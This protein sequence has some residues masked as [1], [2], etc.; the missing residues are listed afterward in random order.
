[1]KR[2]ILFMLCF[3]LCFSAFAKEIDS[4]YVFRASQAGDQ[5]VKMNLSLNIPNKPSQLKIG[6]AGTLGYHYFVTDSINIGGDIGFNYLTTIGENVFYF[7]PFFFKVGYQFNSGKIEYDFDFADYLWLK[8]KDFLEKNGYDQYEVSNFSKKGFES[9]HNLSYW[10]H[11]S[12]LG[13]G[14]GATGTV[15][16]DDGSGIRWTNTQNVESYIN[17]WQ[18]KSNGFSIEKN[19]DIQELEQIDVE[20]SKIEF[21]LMGLRKLSGITTKEYENIFHK[22]IDDKIIRVF[23]KWEQK[24][25]CK[26]Q[27]EHNDS[28]RYSLGKNGILFLNAFLEEIV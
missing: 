12:Y 19:D 23:K 18:E 6:G 10:N 8:A 2:L 22:P 28:V 4:D 15:Y 26:I 13:V 27:N 3:T 11:K 14:S 20:T 7:I 24:N 1:M 16:N 9:K 17:F 5:Y 21:F 25:L